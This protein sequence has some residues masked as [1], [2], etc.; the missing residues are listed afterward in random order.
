MTRAT[1]KRS[2]SVDW[3]W[4]QL[5]HNGIEP[6]AMHQT[7][8]RRE[9]GKMNT[10]RKVALP[11]LAVILV[12]LGLAA[13]ASAAPSNIEIDTGSITI[14]AAPPS[15]DSLTFNLPG[16]SG[17]CEDAGSAT[18]QAD[19][20][21]NGTVTV[22][23]LSIVAVFEYPSGSGNWYMLT[24][25]LESSLTAAGTWLAGSPGEIE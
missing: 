20:M 11:L 13:P 24:L 14:T 22:T 23:D 18:I 1:P 7:H 3:R 8:K 9:T 12:V 17:P 2:M 21:A 6:N 10:K 5:G 16:D 25:E 19:F 15:T 4:P